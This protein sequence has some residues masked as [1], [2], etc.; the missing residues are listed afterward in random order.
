MLF[1]VIIGLK[2]GENTV[3]LSN[4]IVFALIISML[5]LFSASTVFAGDNETISDVV[6]VPMDVDESVGEIQHADAL[7]SQ[8][9]EGILAANN[10]VINIHVTDSYN[11]TSKTWDEDG[12]NLAGA[13]VKVYNSNNKLLNL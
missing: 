6:S 10:N 13:T 5:L 4:K 1:F 3:K 8:S 11:E 12:F 7:N 9:D 2:G